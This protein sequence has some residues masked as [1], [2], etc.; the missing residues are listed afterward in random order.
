MFVY[1]IKYNAWQTRQFEPQEALFAFS[2]YSFYVVF[3]T[4][5]SFF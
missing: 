3:V 4:N 2:F 5:K 1:Y